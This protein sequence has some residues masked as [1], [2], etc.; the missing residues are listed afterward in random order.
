MPG[1]QAQ[2]T[3]VVPTPVN[4]Q[5]VANKAYVDAGGTNHR[6][7]LQT[8][9]GSTAV[10]A[11]RFAGFGVLNNDATGA[12]VEI[13]INSAIRILRMTCNVNT[14]SRNA[15]FTMAV[16]D[17]GVDTTATMSITASTTGQFDTGAVTADIASGSAIRVRFGL[18]AGTGTIEI[19]SIMIE[20]EFT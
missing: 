9:L 16:Q 7:F 19:L 10:T 1:S 2:S 12:N 20:Y 3:L 15:A 4:D 18:A 14:N 13:V 8:G 17:D 5:D 11:N 6:A